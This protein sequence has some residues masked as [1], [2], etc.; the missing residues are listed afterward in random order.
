MTHAIFNRRALLVAGGACAVSFAA[1][2]RAQ[3]KPLIVF[4]AA[5][6]KPVL[7]DLA[8]KAPV[9]Y[10]VSP[11]ASGLLAR[12]IKAG[13][14]AAVFV[15][16]DPKWV[17][18]LLAD[19][20]LQA[21]TRTLLASNE[22]VVVA[23]RRRARALRAL[24]DLPGLLSGDARWVT[25]DPKAA[26][27]GAYV[28]EA[29]KAAGLDTALAERVAYTQD[30]PSAVQL[31]ARGGAAF[32]IVYATDAALSKEVRIV[33]RVPQSLH[34]PILYE[35]ALTAGAPTQAQRLLDYWRGP[36]GQRAFKRFGFLPAARRGC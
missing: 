6:L 15:A 5:S 27:L 11:G 33:H 19:K 35:A 17:D 20:R 22:L 14:P 34:K 23:P 36:A 3:T 29:L 2:A 1:C 28:F 10:V 26:P 16:A 7:E 18:D 12:Q 30:A 4:A 25:A 21:P 13:A 32:A 8:A 9:P 31:A 24:S